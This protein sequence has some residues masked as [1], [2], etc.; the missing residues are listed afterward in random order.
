M[1]MLAVLLDMYVN[2]QPIAKKQSLVFC[3]SAS[4]MPKTQWVRL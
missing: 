2:S 1:L 4:K 3:F